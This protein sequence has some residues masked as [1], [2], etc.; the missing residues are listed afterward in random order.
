[1]QHITS[2]ISVNP[3]ISHGE[4]CIAG[5]RLPVG[6]VLDMI[7]NE[8]TVDDLLNAFPQITRDDVSACFKYAEAKSEERLGWSN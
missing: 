2:R 6:Q 4:P 8:D 7:A 5:T 1:M 3:A